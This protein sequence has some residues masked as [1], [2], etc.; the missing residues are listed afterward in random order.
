MGG[1]IA[2]DSFPFLVSIS[3]FSVC[4]LPSNFD[5]I[6]PSFMFPFSKSRHY[7]C[8]YLQ[9]L[10][11]TMLGSLQWEESSLWIEKYTIAFDSFP[12]YINNHNCSQLNY[13]KLKFKK[14][15]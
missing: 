11:R 12:K 1:E 6:E 4:T 14:I 10:V 13:L 9:N 3:E 2:S 15:K 5:G 7:L 8:L